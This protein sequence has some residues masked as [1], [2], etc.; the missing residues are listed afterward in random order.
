[1]DWKLGDVPPLLQGETPLVIP[2]E[3][4]EQ[5]SP[6]QISSKIGTP[7]NSSSISITFSS[8]QNFSSFSRLI[9][10]TGSITPAQSNE[11]VVLYLSENGISFETTSVNT[12]E[13]GDY[14]VSWNSTSKGTFYARTSWWGNSQFAGA[15]SEIVTIF[16]GFS[17]S[18]LQFESTNYYYL[19]GF[20]GASSY[21]LENRKGLETFLNIQLNGS[22]IVLSGEIMVFSSGKLVTIPK[23][24]KPPINI[25]EISITQGM[26]PLRLPKDIEEKT[27]DQFAVILSN[28][29]NNTYTLDLKGLDDYD[30]SLNGEYNQ[31]SSLIINASSL[32]QENIWYSV[33]AIISMNKVSAIITDEYGYPIKLIDEIKTSDSDNL[34]LLL[35]LTNDSNQV[36]AFKDLNFEP[37]LANDSD[38]SNRESIFFNMSIHF[39]FLFVLLFGVLFALCIKKVKYIRNRFLR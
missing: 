23:S 13:N 25:G 29:N 39:I 12:D 11:T 31:S 38:D 5:S 18:I 26:Q 7:L 9:K 21:E 33:K 22:G 1:M 27:N 20:P 3:N 14:S 17:K 8:T 2:I 19:Y 35:I 36:V 10:I 32:I 34:D 28:D 24:G 37:I 6:A 16:L 30:L 4:V 15:D